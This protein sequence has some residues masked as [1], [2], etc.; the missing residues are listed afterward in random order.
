MRNSLE[1]QRAVAGA[2]SGDQA[3]RA[4]GIP[5]FDGPPPDSRAPYLSVGADT[6]S[7]RGWQG[8]EGR[9]HRFAVSLWDSRE[10]LANAKSVLG[11][12]ERVVLAMPRTANGLRLIGLRLLRASVRRTQRGW[13]LGQLEFRVL[14]VMED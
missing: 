8:G 2:L 3:L 10:G 5:I 4:L 6:V 14:S 9:E 12:V 1:L 13:T 11:E 7:A